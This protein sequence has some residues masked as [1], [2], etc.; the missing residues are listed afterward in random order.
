MIHFECPACAAPF[1]VDERLAG[2]AGRCKRCGGRMKIPSQAAS[3]AVPAPAPAQRPRTMAAAAPAGPRL[4]PIGPMA[5]SRPQPSLAAG[6]PINWLEAVN[7]QVALAPISMDNLRGLGNRPS[8]MDEPSI[9]GPYKL[10][11]AP[12]LPALEA[13]GGKPAGTLTR[14]YRHGMGKVQKLFRWLNESAYLVSVPFLMC[15]LLGLAVG[16]RSL[17]VL[18][19]TAVVVL[20]IG[21]IVAGVANLVVIPFRESPIQGVFFLIPPITFFYMYQNWHKVHKPVKRIVGPILTI[22]L[23]AAAFV[24][25]PLL[26]GGGKSK[27]SLKEQVKSGVGSLKKEMQEQIG[28]VPNLNVDHLRAIQ[29]KAEGALKPLNAGDALKAIEGRLQDAGKSIENQGAPTKP[30]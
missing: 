2:R 8:P 1:D 18:G 15:L 29:N 21:R 19:A 3:E 20:N 10:A 28:K 6:R 16:N 5:P 7:S 17:M 9:P 24:A 23:V 12:S 27:G 25:E 14:G 26:R 22:A 13:I 4:T 11:T 30:R